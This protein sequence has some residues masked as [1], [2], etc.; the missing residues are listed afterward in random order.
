MGSRLRLL[1]SLA[2]YSLVG[3][4]TIPLASMLLTWLMGP[5]GGLLFL[6]ALRLLKFVIL[7]IVF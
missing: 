4:F 2:F 3:E 1:Q 7:I 6:F 5:L